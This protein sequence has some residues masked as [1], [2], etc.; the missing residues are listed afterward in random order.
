ML[1]DLQPKAPCFK[2]YC[3][4]STTLDRSARGSVKNH[5][6]FGFFQCTL[7]KSMLLNGYVLLFFKGRYSLVISFEMHECNRL[8]INK[9]R[10]PI[11][12]TSIQVS[13]CGWFIVI[14]SAK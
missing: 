8:K 5:K 1:L 7:P 2:I 10:S 13:K 3:S 6:D 11:H 4:F 14:F 9:S 12:S